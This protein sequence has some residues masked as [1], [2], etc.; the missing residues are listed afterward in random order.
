[1][2]SYL[3]I[4]GLMGGMKQY[5]AVVGLFGQDMGGDYQVGTMVGYIYQYVENGFTGYAFAGSLLL[6]AIIMVFTI[7]NLRVS[8]KR[9]HY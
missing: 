1:M 2:I 3:L 8:K 4:T 7:I 6:F 5:S 9:V